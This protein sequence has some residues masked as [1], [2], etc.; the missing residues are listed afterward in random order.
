MQ[1]PAMTSGAGF[2]PSVGRPKT[3]TTMLRAHQPGIIT[4][5]ATRQNATAKGPPAAPKTA[6]VPHCLFCM[7][8][9]VCVSLYQCSKLQDNKPIALPPEQY[10][11]V[12]IHF[13]GRSEC[14]RLSLGHQN[15]SAELGLRNR[16][17]AERLLRYKTPELL[18]D[19]CSRLTTESPVPFPPLRP[20]VLSRA[21][22]A[23]LGS[24]WPV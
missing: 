21:L 11:S 13:S 16:I 15:G 24:A 12:Q 3:D 1:F 18:A 9:I 17:V 6:A 14:N 2:Q 10:Y 20:G 19:L 4:T 22:W 23:M 8:V 7:L 5:G